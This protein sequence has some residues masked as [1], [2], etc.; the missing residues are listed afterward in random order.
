VRASE[1]VVLATDIKSGDNSL[2]KFE[3]SGPASEFTA[4]KDIQVSAQAMIEPVAACRVMKDGASQAVFSFLNQN[5]EQL[6][7]EVSIT[8]LDP[9]LLG[10]LTLQ[11]DDLLLNSLDYV[12]GKRVIPKFNTIIDP[13][14]EI[15]QQFISGEGSFAVP[16]E[17][18]LGDLI[19]SILGA[20]LVVN[21][22]TDLC[23]DSSSSI[24]C[25]VL[26]ANGL[27][28]PFRIISATRLDC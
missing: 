16:Y 24:S 3:I 14:R 19:W 27:V 13:G 2:A 21:Q 25:K 23:P 20:T 12:S 28:L 26:D 15:T 1:V 8:G 17:S 22:S 5:L 10:D 18:A 4:E 11:T 9:N 6:T 7:S